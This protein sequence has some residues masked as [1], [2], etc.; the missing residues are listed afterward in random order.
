MGALALYQGFSKMCR[1]KKEGESESS[2]EAA[3]LAAA[4]E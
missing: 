1:K 2:D 3:E 4:I